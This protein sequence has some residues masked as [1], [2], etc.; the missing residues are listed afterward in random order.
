M[1]R[2]IGFVKK[3]FHHIFRD[4]RSMFILFGMPI[5]QI[6]LFGFAITNEIN[7]VKIAILDKS[8]DTETH[9]I[10]Q[11]ISNSS[12][13]NIEQELTSESQIESIFKKGK[14]KADFNSLNNWLIKKYK[15]S[16]I[17]LNENEL[18]TA[19]SNFEKEVVR[20]YFI[21]QLFSKN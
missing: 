14:V 19:L 6:M 3:E 5:A 7:N 12:Y 18:K 13:F 11:K 8:K 20:E 4:R 2:F 10:I 21:K 16:L 9:K 1:K 15:K 17:L